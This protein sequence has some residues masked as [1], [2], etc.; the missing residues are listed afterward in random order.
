MNPASMRSLLSGLVLVTSILPGATFA[1]EPAL[2]LENNFV[3]QYAM[4][5]ARR[6]GDVPQAIKEAKCIFGV[7]ASNLTVQQYI[8]SVKSQSKH[9]PMTAPMIEVMPKIQHECIG[10]M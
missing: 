8:D 7:M 1:D 6:G 5:A 2:N 10:K 4:E 3:N 9:E